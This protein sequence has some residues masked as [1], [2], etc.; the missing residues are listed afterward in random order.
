MRKNLAISAVAF[1]V[2][3]LFSPIV[4]GGES[5]YEGGPVTAPEGAELTA[6]DRV[7][8]LVLARLDELGLKPARLCSDAVFLRRV[9]LATIGTLPTEAETRAFLDSSDEAKRAAA[10]EKLLERPEYVEYWALKWGDLLR[11]KAEFPIKL[12]PNAVQAYHRWIVDSLQEN[13]SCDRIARELLTGNGS[14]FRE[15]EVNFFRA[16]QDRGPRGLAA[17]VALTFMGER[18][19]KWPEKKLDAL[20]GFFAHV[21]YKS[22]A[23]WKEEIVYWDPNGDE[24]GLAA[25]AIFPDGKPVKLDPANHDPRVVF[26]DWLLRPENPLFSRNMSNRIWSWLMG[27]GIVH[28]P[29]DL[30]P[31]NPPS[32]PALLDFLQKEFSAHG[33]DAKHLFR[34]ILNSRTFQLSSIPVKDSPEAAAHFAFYPLRRLEAE[35]LIDALN[36][37]SGTKEEYSSAIPEPFTFVPDDVRAISLGDGSI[38]SSFLELFGRPPRDTGLESER[39][40]NTT[41]QQ[42]LHLL[43]SSHVQNKLGACPLVVRAGELEDEEMAAVVYLNVLS[44]FPAADEVETLKKHAAKTATRGKD[45]AAD[46]VWALVNQPEFFFNH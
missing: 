3:C 1:V 6:S 23:E 40:T 10:I 44:R 15:G 37:I 33:Y 26:A 32:N 35:V 34:V 18:A 38:T 8:Q 29:D 25:G 30:R 12:W 14:N 42:R 19:E 45:L 16:M 24:E 22:T 46:L 41:A 17:T 5:V 36:Q 20:A 13:K 2:G 21:A 4:R 28:E 43:N 11:V 9:H 7:D 31:D 39:G 27:R